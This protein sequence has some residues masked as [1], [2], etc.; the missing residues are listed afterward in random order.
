MNKKQLATLMIFFVMFS[1]SSLSW[2][3]CSSST[4]NY[5]ITSPKQT[6]TVAR[7]KALGPIG[8]VMSISNGP[9]VVITCTGGATNTYLKFGTLLEPSNTPGVYK[10]NVPGI[11][12]KVWDDFQGTLV[13]SNDLQKWYNVSTGS[14]YGGTAWLTGIKMQYYIIGPVETGTVSF[15]SNIIVEAWANTTASASTVGAARYNILNW[16]GTADVTAAACETPNIDVNLGTID[17]GIFIR[18][19]TSPTKSFDFKINNC[20]TGIATVSYLFKPAPGVNIVGTGNNQYLTLDSS[21][22]AKGLGI[23]VLYE[24]G[25]NVPFNTKTALTGYSTSGGSYTIP[26][27]ARYI[28]TRDVGDVEVGTASSTAEFEM[29]YE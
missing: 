24:N 25:N 26:M 2:A 14:G 16:S 19:A 23:Q 1:L 4:S 9:G 11:G 6:I 28:R 8:T 22:T 5:T 27:K 21:S 29:W 18:S 12:I 13:V 7:N 15:P 10:T 20:G 3:G 17:R